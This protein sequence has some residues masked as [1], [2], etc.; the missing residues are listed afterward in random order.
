[1]YNSY[2]NIISDVEQDKSQGLSA[3]IEKICKLIGEPRNYGPTQEEKAEME[4]RAH[5]IRVCIYII[6]KSI[7]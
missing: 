6:N 7:R 2:Q 5:E 1:M 4:R 3:S